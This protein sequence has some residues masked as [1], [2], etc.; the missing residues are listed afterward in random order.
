[1]SIITLPNVNMI[2]NTYTLHLSR[3][4]FVAKL[5][6]GVQRAAKDSV[7]NAIVRHCVRG[8]QSGSR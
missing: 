6:H 1:M 7:S 5:L 2:F 3:N 4:L 8:T